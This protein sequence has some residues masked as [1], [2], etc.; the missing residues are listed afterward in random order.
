MK[1]KLL[2]INWLQYRIDIWDII[3]NSRNKIEYLVINTNLTDNN[4]LNLKI[5]WKHNAIRKNDEIYCINKNRKY[6][7]DQFKILRK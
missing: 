7:I 1:E 6:K 4:M 3:Y 5:V 2:S